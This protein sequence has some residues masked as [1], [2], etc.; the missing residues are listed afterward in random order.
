MQ[1]SFTSYGNYVSL[2]PSHMLEPTD[3]W[4]NTLQLEHTADSAVSPAAYGP[5]SMLLCPV[6][7]KL[8]RAK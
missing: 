1:S 8:S 3:L 4:H 6:M 5:G 7:V 2:C